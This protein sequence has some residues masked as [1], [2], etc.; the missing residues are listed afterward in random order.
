MCQ[1]HTNVNLTLFKWFRTTQSW[2]EVSLTWK[3]YDEYSIWKIYQVW[4]N[5][6]MSEVTENFFCMLKTLKIGLKVTMDVFVFLR[7]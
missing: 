2:T 7:Q 1:L 3:I 5:D 4:T 6:W